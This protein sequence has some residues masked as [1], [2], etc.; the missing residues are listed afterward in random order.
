MSMEEKCEIA[1]G[2]R[3]SAGTDHLGRLKEQIVNI[4][5]ALPP[6]VLL[7]CCTGR[8]AAETLSRRG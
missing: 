5:F 6:R 8:K 4:L 3:V 2:S 7:S 1:E